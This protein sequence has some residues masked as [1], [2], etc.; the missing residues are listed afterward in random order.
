MYEVFKVVVLLAS[1]VEGG[2]SFASESAK[3]IKYY[4]ST[5]VLTL[6]FTSK[7]IYQYYVLLLGL[8]LMYLM[9]LVVSE[10]YQKVEVPNQPQA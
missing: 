2:T 9:T 7:I 3:I 5:P 8:L 6:K 1:A 4:N 10:G